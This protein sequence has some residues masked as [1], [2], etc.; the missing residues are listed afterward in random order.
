MGFDEDT[1]TND[2]R[3]TLSQCR[4]QKDIDLKSCVDQLRNSEEIVDKHQQN[5]RQ[6]KNEKKGD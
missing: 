2:T 3:G 6:C 1:S 5:I 4:E